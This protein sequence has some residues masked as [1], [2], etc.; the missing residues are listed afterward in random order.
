MIDLHCHILPGVDDGSK[1]MA[2]TIQLLKKAEN[3]GFDTIC[4]TPH[5]VEPSY[6]RTKKE[7][8]QILKDVES[9]VKMENI[10]IK[11]LLGNEIFINEN[12]EN[13]LENGEIATLAGSNYALIELPMYQEMP[14]QVVQKILDNVRQKGFKVVI[15]HPERYKYIQK[16]PK[17]VLDYFGEN[18]IFQGNYASIIG[19]YGSDAQKTMKKFLKNRIIHYLSSDVHQVDRCFYDKMDEIK[20][21]IVKITDEE[22]F[23]IMSRI[24]PKLVIE[25]KDVIKFN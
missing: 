8:E 1:D 7:N 2:S 15:A 21:Q 24:N 22:Y 23:E 13:L 17:K 12:I 4:F 9:K 16:N 19:A 10:S 11:L 25:N 6:L 20:N 14:S 3:A 18:V 5:Y